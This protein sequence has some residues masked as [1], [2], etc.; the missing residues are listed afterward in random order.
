MTLWIFLGVSGCGMNQTMDEVLSGED[1]IPRGEAVLHL[2]EAVSLDL[3]ICPGNHYAG[4]YA[5][6]GVIPQ[7]LDQPRYIRS[8]VDTCEVALLL[9]PCG[10]DLTDQTNF[11]NLYRAVLQSCN[12]R[13]P[14]FL[15][16]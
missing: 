6:N 16:H 4:L 10:L 15:S 3:E 11:L 7:M 12:P 13:A 14:G 8:T 1:L 2:Q 5:I 9:T